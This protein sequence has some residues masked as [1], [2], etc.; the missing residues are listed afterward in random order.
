MLSFI[1]RAFISISGLLLATLL[2]ACG[3]STT[4][5]Q[6]LTITGSSTV[7]PLVTEIAKRYESQHESVRIDVQTGGSSRG[8]ADAR[9]QLADIGMAS[10]AL[11]PTETDLAGHLIAIDGVAMIV[12]ADNPVQTLSNEQIVQI[13]QGKLTNWQQVGGLN[14]EIVVINKASG[15]STL[16]VFLKHFKLENDAIQA[17]VI[18]GD[19]E[20]GIKTVSGNMSA[21]GYVS[22]GAAEYQMQNGV[23]IRALP[24]AGVPATT[25]N[26]TNGTFP[27]ARELNLI[28]VGEISPLAQDF[29][30]FA[31]SNAV[32][33]LVNDLSL[34]PVVSK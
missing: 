11:K 16:E 18:I 17:S 13:Y 21:I 2:S 19:N 24:L 1:R 20:Q 23:P 12:H 4:D 14:T 7:A 9:R 22:V 3:D 15:R 33:D 31:Q 25:T 10:R 30:D 34:V 29:I 32:H 5:Q 6:T 8:I 28:T 26:L 27:L